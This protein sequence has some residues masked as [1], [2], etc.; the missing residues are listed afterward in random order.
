MVQ[1]ARTPL[2]QLTLMV[3]R[4]AAPLT[5]ETVMILVRMMGMMRT[6]R[7]RILIIEKMKMG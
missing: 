2:P 6:E 5:M 4:G 1:G 3:A 7:I